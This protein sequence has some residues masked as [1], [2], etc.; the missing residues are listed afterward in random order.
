MNTNN[1]TYTHFA[2][3]N[4]KYDSKHI[5]SNFP[6]WICHQVF[7]QDLTIYQQN[8][9]WWSQQPI[10]FPLD[11]PLR[12]LKGNFQLDLLHVSCVF[13]NLVDQMALKLVWVH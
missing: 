2:K 12:C 6:S 7:H 13:Q 8:L 5:P 10:C 3:T 4:R 9:L 1:V 11:I